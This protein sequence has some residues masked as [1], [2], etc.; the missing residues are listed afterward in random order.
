E[1]MDTSISSASRVSEIEGIPAFI[2]SS[3]EI[4]RSRLIAEA[5]SDLS[6]RAAFPY[7]WAIAEACVGLRCSTAERSA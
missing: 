5:G 2:G 7:L 6:L 4:S 3:P 1:T